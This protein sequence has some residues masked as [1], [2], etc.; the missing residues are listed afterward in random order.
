MKYCVAGDEIYPALQNRGLVYETSYAGQ[1]S[2]WIGYAGQHSTLVGCEGQHNTSLWLR[3][4][5]QC[6]DRL[7]RA[8]VLHYGDAGQHNTWIL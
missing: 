6:L 5:T 2:T 7:R 4:A 3:R 1:H 8:I